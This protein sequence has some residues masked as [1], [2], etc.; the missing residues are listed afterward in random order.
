MEPA[1]ARASC[2]TTRLID[3]IAEKHG[4]IPAQVVLRWHLQLGNVVIP[5]SK[6]PSRIQENFDVFDFELDNDDMAAI[7]DLE[8]AS[9]PAATRTS[10]AETPLP[11]PSP[12][13]HTPARR[14]L[15][16]RGHPLSWRLPAQN[17]RGQPSSSRGKRAGQR[18]SRKRARTGER[19]SGDQATESCQRGRSSD[20]SR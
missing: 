5:K 14:T 11:H 17:L 18:R 2:W 7:A 16:R 13:P 15:Q 10:S 12:H 20:N 1:G 6:T 4:K 3:A 9:A 19:L 8:T